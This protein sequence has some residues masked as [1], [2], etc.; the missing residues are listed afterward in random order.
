MDLH[1]AGVV[2][3]VAE[4]GLDEISAV[5]ESR[6]RHEELP[7]QHR[8]EDTCRNRAHHTNTQNTAVRVCK[9]TG[10]MRKALLAKSW[11]NK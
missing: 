6:Q 3:E 5:R 2:E 1:W 4:N 9:Q 8:V 10:V 11:S 7:R